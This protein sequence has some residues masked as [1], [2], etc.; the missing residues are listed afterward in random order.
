M[1]CRL[2]SFFIFFVF[3]QIS[4]ISAISGMQSARALEIEAAFLVKFSSY[5]K[6]PNEA[7]SDHDDP[8]IIGILGRDPFGSSIDKIARSFR[9]NS[10]GVEI[11]RY[12]DFTDLQKC[13]ILFIPAVEVGQLDKASNGFHGHSVLLVGNSPGFLE[14]SGIINFVSIGNKIRFCISRTNSKKMGLEISSKLL[15]VALTVK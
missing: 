15:A 14:H 13:H 8:I 10:R 12:S 3:L 9:V 7:F 4:T 11:R 2:S 5:V 1:F 6:W